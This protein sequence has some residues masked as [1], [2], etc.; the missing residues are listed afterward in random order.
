MAK[1][2]EDIVVR[3]V[4]EGFEALDKIKGS[5]REL[6]KVTNLAEKDI[7]SAR[8]SLLEFAKK[9]GNTEAVNK[10]LTDA[11]RGLRTQTQ[12]CGDAYREL[13]G[14]IEAAEAASRG[15]T[16]QAEAQRANLAAQYGA[17][18]NNTEA[19]RRQRTA[20][21]ELQQATRGGSQL[22]TQL[23]TDIER[24]TA[25]LDEIEGVQRRT[26]AITRRGLASSAAKANRDLADVRARIALERAAINELNLLTT[27]G[28]RSFAQGELRGP[29]GVTRAIQQRQQTLDTQLTQEGSIAFGENVRQ[30]RDAVRTANAVFSTPEF[31][32]G[33]RSPDNL[34]SAFGPLPNTIAGINQGLSELRTRLDN[35]TIGTTAFVDAAVRA[36][37]AQRELREATLGVASALVQQVRTGEITPSLTNLREVISSVR[38]E[39]A[40]LNTNT[41][42]GALTFQQLE[43]QA[44]L[45]DRQLS[46]LQATQANLAASAVSGF[47][48]F[49]QSITAQAGDKAVEGAIRRNRARRERDL[50]AQPRTFDLDI[51]ALK[52]QL[53]QLN[54]YERQ[55]TEKL[56]E[57]QRRQLP[58]NAA[59]GR[60]NVIAGFQAYQQGGMNLGQALPELPNTNAALAQ[61]IQELTNKFA[62]LTRGTI[63]WREA[64]KE[65]KS[66][67]RQSAEGF[68]V[69][70]AG[71]REAKTRLDA[72]RTSLK[73]VG[74]GFAE[75]SRNPL[76][77]TQAAEGRTAVQKSIERNRR[78]RGLLGAQ[79][80]NMPFGPAEPTELFRG[81]ANIQ[82]QSNSNQLQLMG[83]SY[84]E[85]ATSIR[86]TSAASDSSLNS[87]RAQRAAWESLRN[88]ISGNKTANCCAK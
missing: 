2:V 64:S 58:F 13:S 51:A 1:Q 56:T 21:I 85:V 37:A 50:V 76:A 16:A 23:G 36:A 34:N 68:D 3:L 48:A 7:L 88:M 44:Q 38:T 43:R 67:S 35:T 19:L 22:F 77:L 9:A 17:I 82:G 53:Q 15:Y 81:I 55:Y 59:V 41:T 69:M 79:V 40:L 26:D 86:Q 71:A 6:G 54:V 63:E 8:D 11:F 87:L 62:N 74:S 14:D 70:S 29:S 75:F 28:R 12:L 49:S 20:L 66:L 45:L 60:Q 27:E 31:L 83:R 25:R 78:K 30:R 72:L 4:G 47:A 10:G 84:S 52:R 32:S 65:L 42:N 80:S 24:T 5:F 73:Q 46:T 33:S 57:I 61:S 18:T 39:Q